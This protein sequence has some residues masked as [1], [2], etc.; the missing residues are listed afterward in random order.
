MLER[1]QTYERAQRRDVVLLG[2]ESA[3]KNA[4]V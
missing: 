4:T 1:E 3:T 2:G